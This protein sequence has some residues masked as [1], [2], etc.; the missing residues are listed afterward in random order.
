MYFYLFDSL[1]TNSPLEPGKYLVRVKVSGNLIPLYQYN[2]LEN[3][4]IIVSDRNTPKIT[5]I[6]PGKALPGSMINLNGDFKVKIYN[7]KIF[8]VINM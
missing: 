8:N 3:A 5:N 2:N 1:N 6:I 4:Y 7:G